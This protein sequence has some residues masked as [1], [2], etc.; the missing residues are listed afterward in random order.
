MV[1]IPVPQAAGAA[2]APAAEPGRL[3]DQHDQVLLLQEATEILTVLTA[4][5]DECGAPRRT[6]GRDARG[7]LDRV[8]LRRDWANEARHRGVGGSSRPSDWS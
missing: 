7:T 5:A 6:L 8:D 4:Q 1:A 3:I 2:Q